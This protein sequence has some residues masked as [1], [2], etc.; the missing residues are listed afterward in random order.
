AVENQAFV[1]AVYRV[2]AGQDDIF[3]GH[4]MFIDPLGNVVLQTKEHE[5]GVFTADI[6]LE[7]VDK[8]R[9]QIPVFEDRR[10]DLYH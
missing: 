6:N 3:S 10:T 2:G 1:F 8:V 7:E 4:Y 9:G 5:E